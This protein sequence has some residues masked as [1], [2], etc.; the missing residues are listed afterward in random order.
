MPSSLLGALKVGTL[1][2]L[3]LASALPQSAAPD[4]AASFGR[5][6]EV[7]E[8]DV[9][10]IGGG[11]AG[12]YTSVRLKQQ[13]KSV[14]VVETQDKLGGHTETYK[15][16]A[17]GIPDNFGV[18]FWDNIPVVRTYAD[19]LGLPLSLISVQSSIQ[20]NT[21]YAD[22]RTGKPFIRTQGDVATALGAYA[23]QVFKYPF[24]DDGFNLPDP[25]PADLLLPFGQFVAKY[26]LAAAVNVVFSYGQG[27]GDLLAIPTIYALKLVGRDV[28][29]GSQ[30]GFLVSSDGDQH[31]LYDRALTYLGADALLRSRVLYTHRSDSG[32]QLLVLTPRGPKLVRAKK[33]VIAVPPTLENILPLDPS[34]AERTLFGQLVSSAYWTGLLA[35]TGLPAGTIATNG[36]PDTPYQLPPLPGA[37]GF[38]PAPAPGLFN[39]KYGAAAPLPDGRVKADILA[40]LR[41]LGTSG[42]FPSV[43][44]DAARFVDFRRHVPFNLHVSGDAIRD[45]FYRRVNALQGLRSTYYTGAAWQAQ[46]S[47]LIWNFTENHVLPKLLA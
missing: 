32:V 37:Y 21:T 1:L 11:S 25:V 27:I 10:V 26:N 18:I 40:E 43:T 30:T 19:S 33:L 45:G 3:G 35:D 16:P 20:G 5:Y 41:R 23:Q 6:D 7:I 2:C 34:P 39:I 24:L 8:R 46:N 4:G 15:D 14:V 29:Q 42:T 47:A 9:A 12:T 22:F 28:L 38:Y 13:G 36:A 44:A 31:S 17:T